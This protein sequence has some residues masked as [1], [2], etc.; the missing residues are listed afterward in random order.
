MGWKLASESGVA[1]K[2]GFDDLSTA[3]L[4]MFPLALGWNSA[5]H[6]VVNQAVINVNS[7][8][9]AT[10]TTA[11]ES[12]AV[13]HDGIRDE[14]CENFGALALVGNESHQSARISVPAA[15]LT[16]TGFTVETF[17]KFDPDNFLFPDNNVGYLFEV[18]GSWNVR[19]W[20][21][22]GAISWTVGDNTSWVNKG[23]WGNPP[24]GKNVDGDWH[25]IAFV[26]D[27]AASTSTFYV[28]YKSQGSKSGALSL[29][30]D[31][32]LYI[33]GGHWNTTTGIFGD[34]LLDEVKVTRL[35]LK[36]W[37][38]QRGDNIVGPTLLWADFDDGSG[39]D[40]EPVISPFTS[41]S[42]NGTPHPAQNAT[43]P[44]QTTETVGKDVLNTANTAS[45]RFNNAGYL[46]FATPAVLA[47]E[48][49]VEMFI[50]NQSTGAAG[51]I[52]LYDG[53]S[54]NDAIWGLELDTDGATPVFV[55]GAGVSQTR[56]AFTGAALDARWHH[57][58]FVMTT[59]DDGNST[60]KFFLD[61]ELVSTQNLSVRI[62]QTSTTPRVWL[63]RA[64]NNVAFSGYMD[65][66]R[67]SEGELSAGD[68]MLMKRNGL[69]IVFR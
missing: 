41:S 2:L 66:V 15:G 4:D 52:A 21:S 33:A 65:E 57:L 45:M 43:V 12:V 3:G 59:P 28:D 69:S 38:F 68:M 44:A 39:L 46:Y 35:A 17:V 53:N 40:F 51:M 67:I 24:E 9:S 63:G 8:A 49:T 55:V 50:K 62:R 61:G 11:D 25:H 42:F 14:G 16:D 54:V 29:A 27:A 47:P 56:V 19:F 60:V 23:Y 34:A 64:T 36:P 13:V 18:S 7:G 31:G 20:S 26:Y 58:A 10:A 22:S 48:V 30:A 1:V 37:E 6:P 5:A 32:K